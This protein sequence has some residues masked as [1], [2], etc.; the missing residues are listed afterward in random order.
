MRHT[1]QDRSRTR[2]DDS[3]SDVSEGGGTAD[4]SFSSTCSHSDQLALLR[5]GMGVCVRVRGV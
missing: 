5:L 2:N 3:Y 4:T 1:R